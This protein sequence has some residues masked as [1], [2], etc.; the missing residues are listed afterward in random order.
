MAENRKRLVDATRRLLAIGTS[1]KDALQSMVDLGISEEEAKSIVQEAKEPKKPE[2]SEQPKT[3]QES[4]DL[5]TP[6]AKISSKDTDSLVPFLVGDFDR[7]LDKGGVKKGDVILLSGSAGTGKTTFCMEFLYKGA[8]IKEQKGIFFTIDEKPSRLKEKFSENFYWDLDELEKQGFFAVFS[9][10]TDY[11][12]RAVEAKAE[13]EQGSLM[14]DQ[15]QVKLPFQDKLPFTPQR[16]VVDNLSALK[17]LLKHDVQGFNTYVKSLFQY[18]K[19]TEAVSIIVDE[20][21][22]KKDLPMILADGIIRLY[23]VKT[24]NRRETGLE[25]IKMRSTSHV[26]KLVPFRITS[27]GFEVF[28]FEEF[29]Y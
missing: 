27:K 14:I 21:Q 29:Y 9:L 1:E 3:T 22:S 10:D 5:S 4:Y 8:K 19:S 20:A 18:L 13:S 17:V 11:I 25:I 24:K 7:L 28:P 12:I 16:I 15:E 26:K 23:S 2:Q 6:F